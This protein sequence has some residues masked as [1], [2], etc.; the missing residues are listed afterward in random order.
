MRA[1]H[2]E[3]LLTLT[4]LLAGTNVLAQ[5]TATPAAPDTQAATEAAREKEKA[6]KDAR[7]AEADAQKEKAEAEAEAQKEVKAAREE[8]KAAQDVRVRTLQKA[9]RDGIAAQGD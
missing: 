7:E 8:A 1:T 2:V 4:L 6:E 5:A 3:A 9:I